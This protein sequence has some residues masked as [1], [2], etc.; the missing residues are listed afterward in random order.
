MDDDQRAWPI[1]RTISAWPEITPYK[2]LRYSKGRYMQHAASITFIDIDSKDEAWLG[3]RYDE[4]KVALALSLKTDGDI[5]VVMGKENARK[6]IAALQ[7]AT[8]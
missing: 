4:T 3:V 7:Q 8:A 1:H 5:E 6:L 2:L